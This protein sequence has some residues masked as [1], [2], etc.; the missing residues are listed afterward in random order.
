MKIRGVRENHLGEGARDTCSM[1]RT[2][3][4]IRPPGPIVS[5]AYLNCHDGLE[6]SLAP[7]HKFTQ[8]WTRLR[9]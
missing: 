2:Q 1:Q 4:E 6:T 8:L 9:G 3:R 5:I 7:V